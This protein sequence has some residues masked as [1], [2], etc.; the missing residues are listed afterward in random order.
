MA[1]IFLALGSISL[2]NFPTVSV[3]VYLAFAFWLA[4]E[5]YEVQKSDPEGEMLLLALGI[6]TAFVVPMLLLIGWISTIIAQISFFYL[7]LGWFS[8]VVFVSTLI[9]LHLKLKASAIVKLSAAFQ[10]WAFSVVAQFGYLYGRGEMEMVYRLLSTQGQFYIV[11]VLLPFLM[12]LGSI[13]FSLL[14]MWLGLVDKD[15]F[16]S[17]M[18]KRILKS[19]DSVKVKPKKK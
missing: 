16:V 6:T 17:P 11:F 19:D 15:G 10:A 13:G 1:L 2:R 3:L 8:V 14:P 18:K 7:L 5:G 12:L 4:I 9:A